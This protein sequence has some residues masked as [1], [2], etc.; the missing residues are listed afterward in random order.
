MYIVI[1]VMIVFVVMML[2]GKFSFALSG[3]TCVIV[4]I[5]TGCLS[6]TEGF[7]GLAD[8][9][10]VLL[11]GMFLIAGLL[12]R[13]SLIEKV[14]NKLLS[15][16]KAGADIKL[17]ATILVIGAI[18][19]QLIP[20]QTGIIMIVMSFLAGLGGA[21][22][23]T[24]SRML[25]PVTFVLTLW[26]GRL[27]IGAP[28]LTTHLMIN[29]LLEGA[30]ATTAL[31]L[32]GFI[33]ATL[34]PAIVGLVY[35][36]FTYKMLPK[37]DVTLE[38]YEKAKRPGH[39]APK[40]SRRD[41]ILVYIAF[42]LS[43][44]FLLFAAQIGELAYVMP[45]AI[46]IVLIFLHVLNGNEVLNSIVHGPVLM[47]APILVMSSA[48]TKSGAG[49]LI[50]NGILDMLGGN[51]H[52]ILILTV[53]AFVAFLLSSFVS[54]TACFMVLIPVAA[55]VCLAAGFDPRACAVVVFFASNST[56]ITPMASGG[57]ALAY[58]TCHLGIR[59]TWK[60][61]VPAGLL[62]LITSI[63]SCYIVY[64]MV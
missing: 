62:V 60:W 39:E 30:G 59:Q 20:S 61:T 25:I 32:P 50:G 27:P 53:F 34:P 10:V 13:T 48:M 5:L 47:C 42:A 9:N 1:A 14:K 36:I 57:A 8:K 23:V 64:P 29:Q 24:V 63:I 43:V 52:P 56:I 51:P 15:N 19:A 26:L 7:S 6:L 55:T 2:S 17:A 54:N 44:F 31:S 18:L 49:D 40:M 3:W 37:E 45:L 33:A 28:G 4:M 38:A 35:A 21:T 46:S 16:R 58:S 12:G 22:E 41:E 11:A